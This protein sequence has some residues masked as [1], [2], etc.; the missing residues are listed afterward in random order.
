MRTNSQLKREL[1]PA[2]RYSV[3]VQLNPMQV[4]IV[5]RLFK[6]GLWGGSPKH[7]VERLLCEALKPHAT[8]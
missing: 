6:T 5:N 8:P 1:N 7:V 4:K 2:S 3:Y